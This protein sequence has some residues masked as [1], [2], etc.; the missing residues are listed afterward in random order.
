MTTDGHIKSTDKHQYLH[1]T[2]AHPDHTK[3]SI[4]LVKPRGLAGYAII[5]QILKD[6]WTISNHGP[7]QE[8]TLNIKPKRKWAKFDLIKKIGILNKV[9]LKE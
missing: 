2:S 1:Y 6:I 9:N 7:K 5:K 4:F 3:R 8:A